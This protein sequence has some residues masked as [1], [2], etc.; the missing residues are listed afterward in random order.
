MFNNTWFD[1]YCKRSHDKERAAW[2]ATLLVFTF[3]AVCAEFLGGWLKR[4]DRAQTVLNQVAA[5]AF[6]ALALR[7]V[8]AAR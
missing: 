6:L 1:D 8:V 3:V 2:L 5:A 7:L 4:S